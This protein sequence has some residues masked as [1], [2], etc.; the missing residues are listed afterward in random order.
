M[1]KKWYS[2]LQ[3]YF[4]TNHRKSQYLVQQVPHILTNH[5][6]LTTGDEGAPS[7]EPEGEADRESGHNHDGCDQG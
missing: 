7:P 5:D 6:C 2:I 4:L 1:P 3:H